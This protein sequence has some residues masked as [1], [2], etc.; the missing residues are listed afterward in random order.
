M[1]SSIHFT[2]VKKQPRVKALYVYNN[3]CCPGYQTPPEAPV[4]EPSIKP[5]WLSGRPMPASAFASNRT[6]LVLE[7]RSRKG[8]PP[9]RLPIASAYSDPNS[10]LFIEGAN[11]AARHAVLLRRLDEVAAGVGVMLRIVCV[12]GVVGLRLDRAASRASD[13]RGANNLPPPVVG[14]DGI[15]QY[16]VSPWLAAFRLRRLIDAGFAVVCTIDSR[17]CNWPLLAFCLRAFGVTP[18]LELMRRNDDP[19][20]S[21][22]TVT[23][24]M[25]Q[26]KQVGHTAEAKA[27]STTISGTQQ[28]QHNYTLR[29]SFSSARAARLVSA[30]RQRESYAQA[31]ENVFAISR[32]LREKRLH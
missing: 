32:L 19:M 11:T 21:R 6:N 2:N 4:N 12:K 22:L 17:Q 14:I 16:L 27:P 18:R 5:E 24:R 13:N 31:Y 20:P 26:I 25:K 23:S 28:P 9:P 3:P 8:S 30:M 10:I 1:N 29:R 15:E 7:E